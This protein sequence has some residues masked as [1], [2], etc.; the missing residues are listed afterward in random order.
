MTERKF[1]DNSKEGK[2]KEW[3]PFFYR[4]VDMAN[5]TAQKRS[6][7][8]NPHKQYMLDEEKRLIERTMKLY[9]IYI[10]S[11]VGKDLLLNA[12]GTELGKTYLR[13][14]EDLQVELTADARLQTLNYTS[15]AF[16]RTIGGEVNGRKSNF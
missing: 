13:Q 1:I 9:E 10:T 4:L 15:A 5:A 16:T 7:E 8:L 3:S 2:T 12:Q 14:L 11:G 6:I